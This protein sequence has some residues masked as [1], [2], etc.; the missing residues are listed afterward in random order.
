LTL[1]WS[2]VDRAKYSSFTWRSE[3]YA[4]EKELPDGHTRDFSHSLGAYSYVQYQLSERWFAGLRGDVVRPVVRDSGKLAWDLVPYLTFWQSEFVYLRLEGQHAEH[5]PYDMPS[6]E[7][8]R[9]TDN[10][11]LLQIDFAAGPHKHEKY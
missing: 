4:A 11:L 1:Y 7:L 10:R 5:L 2:P 8:G 6:G 9:R 3:L